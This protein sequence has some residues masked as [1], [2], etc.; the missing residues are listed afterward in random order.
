MINPFSSPLPLA[1][2]THLHCLFVVS[3]LLIFLSVVLSVVPSVQAAR[4][5]RRDPASS[6]VFSEVQ[7]VSPPLTR[8]LSSR[9]LVLGA[10]V[11]DGLMHPLKLSRF[12][13]LP[14]LVPRQ[15]ARAFG[16]SRVALFICCS[17]LV[18]QITRN[19]LW[20][21]GASTSGRPVSM[22]RRL[23]HIFF[24]F[25]LFSFFLCSLMIL[26]TF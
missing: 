18:V 4:S 6:R 9:Q 1:P 16:S 22:V 12:L 26:V 7:T 15:P 20:T 21:E 25:L 24:F 5:R 17:V 3:W 11:L 8:L 19:K 2:F 10:L 23:T 13:P 14:S